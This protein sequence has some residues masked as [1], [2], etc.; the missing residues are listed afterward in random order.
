MNIDAIQRQSIVS[1]IW[2]IT[3]TFIGFFSTIYFTRNVGASALGEYFLFLAY[4]GIITLITDGGFGGA[5]IKRISEGE[6]QDAYFSAFFV[7]RS[8]FVTF[9]LVMLIVLRSYFDDSNNSSIFIWFSVALI[10]SLLQ[11]AVSSGMVGCGK[12]GIQSTG[13]FIDNISRIFIQIIAVFFGY[14]AAGLAGGFI[15]GMFIGCV[16]QLHFFDLRF[17]RFKWKHIKSLSSFSLWIFLVSSGM[18]VYSNADTIMIGYYLNTTDV[19]IYRIVLQ[20][21]LLSTFT[22]Y[23]L[24][25]TLW[26]RV[27]RWGKVG[28]MGLIEKSISRAFTYSLVLTI[29]MFMGGV[30]LG[31][32]LLLYF[33]GREY[34]NGYLTMVILFIAQIVSIFHFFSTSYLSALGLFKD[35]LKITIAA[36][37][38]NIALNTILIPMVGI[39][40]AAI[41][42]LVTMGLNAILALWILSKTLTIRIESKSLINI[43]KASFLMSL[44]I[45]VYRM[46]VPLSDVWL[47]LVP[48][49]VGGGIYGVL[50]LKYDKEIYTDVC[51]ICK[52]LIKD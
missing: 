7:L 25:D 8:L 44:F 13:I 40:G 50:V 32:K 9:V 3:F 49:I 41:A 2:K 11:G 16:V 31:D 10:V 39:E 45:S 17:V 37:I 38:A 23:V 47:A 14:G 22:A 19:G 20:F 12:I 52:Q 27:S 24:R 51:N 29:P 36:V 46:L 43:L 1:L 30:L 42:T 48:V 4:F 15:A 26:P 33:Y 35:L 6:E 28:E 21:T 34:G 5:A 18:V